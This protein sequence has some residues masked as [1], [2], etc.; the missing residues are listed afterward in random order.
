LHYSASRGK[1]SKLSLSDVFFQALNAPK[2]V[3]SRTPQGKLVTLPAPD[4]QV[5]WEDG[6]R[7]LTHSHS[8]NE[9]N[10]AYVKP[11]HRLDKE[12]YVRRENNLFEVFVIF[13]LIP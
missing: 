9:L 1:M 5:D 3:F 13:C 7:L 11:A 12:H 10:L 8:I 6:H 2:L 4:L